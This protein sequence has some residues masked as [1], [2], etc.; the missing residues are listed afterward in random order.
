MLKR[1]GW[2]VVGGLAMMLLFG[3]MPTRGFYE[4][5]EVIEDKGGGLVGGEERVMTQ[6]L[7]RVDV[8]PSMRKRVMVIEIN[9]I[10]NSGEVRLNDYMGWH[11]IQTLE[12]SM[13]NTLRTSTGGLVEYEVVRREEYDDYPYHLDG[14]KYSFETWWQC[15]QDHNTCHNTLTDYNRLLTEFQVCEL[16]NQ[17]QIDEL[18]FWVGPW[19]GSMYEATMTGPDAFHTNGPPIAGN[20]CERQMHV[21]ALNPERTYD[22]ALHAYV[23][24]IEGTMNYLFGED[25]RHLP[26][27]HNTFWGK[28][29]SGD[30]ALPGESGCGWMHYTPNS[31]VAYEYNNQRV[32]QSYCQDW[33]AFPNLQ[34]TKTG[35][36]CLDWGCTQAG[37][38]SWWLDHLPRYTGQVEGKWN[39]WWR[40]VLDYEEV[41]NPIVGDV[42]HDRDLD[43]IDVAGG[44]TQWN[45]SDCGGYADLNGDCRVDVR[46]YNLQ[47]ANFGQ[48]I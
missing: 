17:K 2:L 29:A 26:Y 28:F 13:I 21:L 32:V 39:N 27:P 33:Y 12:N 31:L 47:F 14:F 30:V 35:V 38:I 23:H 3:S 15:W 11:D 25:P 42:D 36:N 9:P 6:S 44:L 5:Y 24:R 19:V 46:D 16:R 40:Y 45:Q 43:S 48:D 4:E 1:I 10:I 37:F 8:E 22:Y 7:V 18:W 41:T 20:G 34:E